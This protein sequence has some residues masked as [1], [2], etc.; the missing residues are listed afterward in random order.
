MTDIY[1]FIQNFDIV[2]S[3]KY[4]ED[5]D[6]QNLEMDANRTSMFFRE[7]EIFRRKMD[8]YYSWK[9]LAGQVLESVPIITY[10]FRARNA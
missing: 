1:R 8:Y 6:L 2:W 10:E 3:K 5:K 9:F 7:M 4:P